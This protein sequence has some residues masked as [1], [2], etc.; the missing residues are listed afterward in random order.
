MAAKKLA[1]APDTDGDG[2]PDFLDTDSDGDGILDVDEGNVDT[3]GDLIP[4]YR[5]LD[6][7]GDCI[8]DAPR[9]ATP[10][11]YAAVDTD[12]D[13]APDF[14]DID[15]DNDGLVDGKEDKNCNGVVDACE[16]DR[17]K[18]DTDGDG[19][20]DLVEVADC[21]AKPAG[22]AGGR[23]CATA[24]NAASSP[25]THGDFVFVVDY[26]AAAVADVGDAQPVDRR[27][28]GRR[29]LL[30]RHHRL[31]GQRASTT[32]KTSLSGVAGDGAD[33]GQ[34]RG[35]GRRR[36]PRLHRRRRRT[37]SPTTIASPPS[38]RRPG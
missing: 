31:D 14:V 25:L 8:P 33:E 23:A 35:H 7:D 18:A 34:E 22:A 2:I 16:T 26:N 9:P 1:D 21:A 15:S 10:I 3:D 5:D 29:H 20:S 24:P 6:S 27:Q 30:D 17:K 19:V 13:G 36:L 11:R 4:N 28:P 37:S 38:R 12:G 32:C